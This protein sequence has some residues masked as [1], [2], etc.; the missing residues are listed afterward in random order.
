MNTFTFKRP[1]PLWE[2]ILGYAAITV[3][4]YLLVT[5]LGGFISI[6]IGVYLL[7]KEGSEIDFDKMQYRNIKSIFGLNFGKWKPLP[8]DVEYISVF[9]TTETTTLRARSAEAN[10]SND[11]IKLNL[12]YNR[13]QKITAYVTYDKED[14]FKKAHELA[15][16]LNIDILDATERESKWL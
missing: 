6:G 7:L 16:L 1:L 14:A 3:G 4:V 11:I 8:D 15:S 10:V 2:L 13:N 5:S 12:F 9:K